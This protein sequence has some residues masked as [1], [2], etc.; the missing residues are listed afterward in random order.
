MAE[1]YQVLFWTFVSLT[2]LTAVGFFILGATVNRFFYLGLLAVVPLG[3]TGYR[4]RLRLVT[5]RLR[6]TFQ[7]LWGREHERDRDFG[8]LERAYDLFTRSKPHHNALD[9]DTWDDLNMDL[10]YG[11]ADRTHTLPGES[12]LY[13]TLRCPETQEAPLAERNRLVRLFQSDPALREAVG[14]ELLRLGQ[15]RHTDVAALLWGERPV[16]PPYSVFFPVLAAAPALLACAGWV[17]WPGFL[18]LG[19]FPLFVLNVVITQC[20]VRGKVYSQI[21]ALRYLGAMIARAQALGKLKHPQLAGITDELSR[22]SAKL[23]PIA[24]R[25]SILRPEQGLSVD[26]CDTLAEYASALFLIE[27]RTFFGVLD[28][29][30]H[31]LG[32]LRRLHELLGRLDAA[33]SVASLREE[34]PGYSDPEFTAGDGVGLELVH[35]R[36]PLLSEPV[37]NSFK[38]APGGA[39][40]SGSNM[41]GKSTFLRTVAVNAILGQTLYTCCAS[42]Y[43]ASFFRILSSINHADELDEGK[44]YY[45]AEAERLLYI[46]QAVGGDVPCLCV[47]DELLRGTNAA[48][49]TSA[50]AAILAHLCSQNAL[51]LVASHDAEL[52][53][54][55]TG[56][57]EH[58]HFTD[59]FDD[60]RL[61][62]DYRLKPGRG[63]TRNA[64]KLLESLGYPASVVEEARARFDGMG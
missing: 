24:R 42:R 8:R 28:A 44:S 33:Q 5:E 47:V 22:L 9:D 14:A 32:P 31:N 12:V 52:A 56:A 17:S 34:L 6:A 29:L 57:M 45:L 19:T 63:T 2:F 25:T 43:H 21:S 60:G 20:L 51:V 49:R 62:F 18:I 3:F 41:S 7:R 64:I 53:S 4:M 48:E 36:H 10:V 23:A 39:F 13:R 59:H 61:R 58:Y 30:E 1:R 37:T 15:P 50:S 40:I 35:V 16:K 46:V 55:V 26:I 54:V 11:K 38:P 27:V